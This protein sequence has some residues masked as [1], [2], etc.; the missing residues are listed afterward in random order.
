MLCRNR[1]RNP[2][3]R[4]VKRTRMPKRRDWLKRP[5]TNALNLR[6]EHPLRKVVHCVTSV[7]VL[8][9]LRLNVSSHAALCTR[10]VHGVGASAPVSRC[11]LRRVSIVQCLN[12][13]TENYLVLISWISF[14]VLIVSANET[15][16]Q[17]WDS[18]PQSRRDIRTVLTMQKAH[19]STHTYDAPNVLLVLLLLQRL[20]NASHTEA[21]LQGVDREIDQSS[22]LLIPVV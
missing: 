19:H 18:G 16:C 20:H 1:N 10:I 6:A 7:D 11:L 4:M 13:P 5:K 15:D 3:L 17:T 21:R 12:S 8:T 14:G 22:S 9:S 2:G